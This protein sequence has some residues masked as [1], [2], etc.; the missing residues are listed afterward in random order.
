M[1]TA[2]T[3]VQLLP[4]ITGFPLETFLPPGFMFSCCQLPVS[5]VVCSLKMA[6]CF[7][8]CQESGALRI[9]KTTVLWGS[10]SSTC[11]HPS[12][13]GLR[14]HR[15]GERGR[16]SI[17]AALWGQNLTCSLPSIIPLQLS[18]KCKLRL[19]ELAVLPISVG[20]EAPLLPVS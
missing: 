11:R 9:Q 4:L 16:Y 13:P 7:F 2:A 15:P 10:P 12:G 1:A 19:E 14:L 6:A 3:T 8:P 17:L 20:V 5:H 18:I